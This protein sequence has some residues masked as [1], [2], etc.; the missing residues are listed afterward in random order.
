MRRALL[1]LAVVA[2]AGCDRF[3]RGFGGDGTVE[4][5]PAFNATSAVGQGGGI[6]VLGT[7]SNGVPQLLRYTAD[8]ALDP[9]FGD[10]GVARIPGIFPS[11]MAVAA[12]PGSLVVAGIDES[13]SGFTVVRHDPDGAVRTVASH[14]GSIEPADVAV[15]P[16]GVA[17]VP[18]RLSTHVAF[19]EE[20]GHSQI[21]ETPVGDFSF[22]AAT[23]TLPDGSAV[24]GGT[25]VRFDSPTLG[26]LLLVRYRPD[27]TIDTT[28][29]WHGVVLVDLGGNDELQ[30][31]VV[32]PDG[33]IVVSAHSS[34]DA[35]T[36]HWIV[37]LTADGRPDGRSRAPIEAHAEGLTALLRPDGRIVTAGVSITGDQNRDALTNQW[38]ADL[39]PDG[40]WGDGGSNRTDLGAADGLLGA[41]L[42]PDG[43]LLAVTNYAVVR[44]SR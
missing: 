30:D 42:L 5:P 8:G 10:D 1:V 2:L 12:A 25:S 34:R 28:F 6:V 16:D 29:G 32:A 36:R 20:D 23:A 17:V 11:V 4:L 41:A 18:N 21:V 14:F 39:R 19:V 40:G 43:R 9:A 37:R 27:R 24:V 38:L 7:G 26:D 44:Y 3:D 33:R 22:N 15:A 13:R 35:R 31:I